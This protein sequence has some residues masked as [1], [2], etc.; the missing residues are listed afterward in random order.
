MER[1]GGWHFSYCAGPAEIREKIQAYSHQEYNRPEFTDL[2]QIEA[3]RR[4]A[5]DLFARGEMT[6]Q[7]VPVDETFPRY[8]RENRGRFAHLVRETSS[9]CQGRGV[10]QGRAYSRPSSTQR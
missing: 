6:F 3:A 10:G 5:R 8:V 2:A 4:R 9:T 7:I 1:E